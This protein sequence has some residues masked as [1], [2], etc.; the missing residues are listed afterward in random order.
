MTPIAVSAIQLLPVHWP[1]RGSEVWQ[2]LTTEDPVGQWEL[3]LGVVELLDRWSAALAGCDLLHL[4][5][6]D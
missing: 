4:H 2:D 6:L 1:Q 5:D 3:D